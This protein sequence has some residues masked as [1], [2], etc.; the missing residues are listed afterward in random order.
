MARPQIKSRLR[1][2][3]ARLAVGFL[4][5]LSLGCGATIP[6]QPTA[7]PSNLVVVCLDTVRYDTFWLPE[8]SGFEDPLTPWLQSTALVL[9]RAQAPAPWTV[10]SVA[11]LLSGLYPNQ[12]GAG[13]F[14]DGVANL[15][16]DVPGGMLEQATTLPEILAAQGYDTAAF[17]A[18]PWFKAPYGLDRGFSALHLR[19]GRRELLA[20]ALSWLEQRQ[21]PPGTNT[22]TP[23]RPFLLYLHLMEAHQKHRAPPPELAKAVAELPPGMKL[24]A[25]DNAPSE[26]CREPEVIPCLRFQAYVAA[27]LELRESVAHLLRELDD[28]GLSENTITVVF[29]DHGEEFRDHF[30][31]QKSRASDPRKLYGIGH[32]QSLFQELLHVPLLIWHP[33]L[34]GRRLEA[35]ASLIDVVP[36]LLEWLGVPA[37]R[38]RWPGTPISRLMPP[39]GRAASAQQRYLF[40]SGIAYGPEQAAVRFGRWKRIRDLPSGKGTLFDLEQDPGELVPRHADTV[41]ASLDRLLEHYLAFRPEGAGEAPDIAPEELERLQSLGYLL[42]SPK[43]D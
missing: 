43:S 19:A 20:A 14:D 21:P 4:G 33:A 26:A 29:S 3:R 40:A 32:G 35:E 22:A 15:D 1:R 7:K 13:R 2:L 28:R 38:P 36:S 24:H 25:M 18:H 16:V 41:S 23:E 30:R 10:P 8:Q 31:E 11:S 9:T 17:V 27:V 12:H 37:P 39:E 6:E 5:C 34:Q 42:G